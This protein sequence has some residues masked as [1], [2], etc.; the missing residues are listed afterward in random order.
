MTFSDFVTLNT[1]TNEMDILR[2]V[3]TASHASDRWLFIA[4]LALLGAF[5]TAVMRKLGNQNAE[6]IVQLKSDR[7]A[8][9]TSLKSII[10]EQHG[11][12]K[13]AI[14]SQCANTTALELNTAALNTFSGRIDRQQHRPT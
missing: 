2:A 6:L 12:L 8:Y 11:Q 9:E 1:F 10:S 4:T 13:N 7:T 14:E 3:E 5:A